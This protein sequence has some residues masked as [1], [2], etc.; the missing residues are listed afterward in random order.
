MSVVICG[1]YAKGLTK[2]FFKLQIFSWFYKTLYVHNLGTQME[3]SP[4]SILE[5][6]SVALASRG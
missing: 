6:M 4:S 3:T 5:V 1:W 2:Q